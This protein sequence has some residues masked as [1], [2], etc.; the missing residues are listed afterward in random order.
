[1]IPAARTV[2]R[3]TVAVGLAV[4]LLSLGASLA[5]AD[6][7]LAAPLTLERFMG[8]ISRTRGVAAR[9]RE[10][11]ELALL[12]EPLE[13][14]GSLYFAPPDRLARQI[15]SPAPSAMVINGDSLVVRD[16]AGEDRVDLAG[17]ETAR[18]FVDNFLVLFNGDLERLRQRYEVEFSADERRW[19][20]VL[21]P[22][23]RPMKYV[24][25]RIEM[26]GEG[27]ALLRMSTTEVEGDVTRTLFEDVDT[28]RVFTPEELE[29]LFGSSDR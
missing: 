12:S 20:L 27:P 6:D 10:I 8:E 3:R 26:E 19:T 1:M 29:R 14:R 22:R 18:Q 4:A 21:R 7:E 13:S 9:F 11:K 15:H 5:A 28:D 16:E 17:N 23:A 25:E 2:R 24:I